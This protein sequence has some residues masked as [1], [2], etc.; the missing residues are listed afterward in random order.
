MGRAGRDWVIETWNWDL[1]AARLL[2]ALASQPV[3]EVAA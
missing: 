2:D 1:L 3:A